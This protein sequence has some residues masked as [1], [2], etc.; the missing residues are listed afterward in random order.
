[1]TDDTFTT[2][3]TAFVT[4]LERAG[5]G[6]AI[7]SCQYGHEAHW[8]GADNEYVPLHAGDLRELLDDH[9]VLGRRVHELAAY[10]DSLTGAVKAASDFTDA[11]QQIRQLPG[12]TAATA[13]A[14]AGVIAKAMLQLAAACVC[15]CIPGYCQDC[16][17][18]HCACAGHC[19]VCDHDDVDDDAATHRTER[20]QT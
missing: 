11:M 10:A 19:P 3:L 7:V 2:R 12:T 5:H 15:G 8:P 1:M 18:D 6:T 4:A 20:I 17:P 14:S 9:A 13:I 16:A